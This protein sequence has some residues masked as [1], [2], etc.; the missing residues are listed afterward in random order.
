M[1]GV[2]L[3][4]ARELAKNAALSPYLFS[5]ARGSERKMTE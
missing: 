1:F 4:V 3:P 5:P 2:G